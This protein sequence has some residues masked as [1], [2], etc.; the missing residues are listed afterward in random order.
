MEMVCIEVVLYS[1]HDMVVVVPKKITLSPL[2]IVPHPHPNSATTTLREE[3]RCARNA[4]TGNPSSGAPNPPSVVILSCGDSL[5]SLAVANP[6]SM[7]PLPLLPSVTQPPGDSISSLCF[8]PR[9][10]FVVATSWDN[11]VRCWE[12]AR[13]G[14][15][16]NSTPKASTSHDQPESSVERD[17]IKEIFSELSMFKKNYDHLP[18]DIYFGNYKDFVRGNPNYFLTYENRKSAACIQDHLRPNGAHRWDSYMK[19]PKRDRCGCKPTKEDVKRCFMLEFDRS[20]NNT[21]MAASVS[22]IGAIKGTPVSLNGSGAVASSVPNSSAFFG[23]NLKKVT[24]RIHSSSRVS[25]GSFK[26]VAIDEDK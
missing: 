1:S 17:D 24:S 23:S 6:P 14:T 3:H 4:S 10:N 21:A 25:S 15:V 19:S 7:L 20:D 5:C 22:T 9:A 26:I 12:V 2:F 8:S 13:N 11:Q 18:K 16:I